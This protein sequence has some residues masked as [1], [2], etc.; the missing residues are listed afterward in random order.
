MSRDLLLVSIALFTWGVGESAYFFF[1]PLY[2][3]ALGASPLSIGTIMG[4]VGIA[5]II[6]HIPAGYLADR[7]GRR[8]MMWI[9]W[10][11]GVLSGVIMASARSLPIFTVGAVL[12]GVTAFV[13]TPLNSYVTAARGKWSV[14]RALTLTSAAYSSGAIVGPIVGGYI[15]ERYDFSNL[16]LFATCMF[17]LS[18]IV[19]FFLKPQPTEKKEANDPQNKIFKRAYL[20]FL[21]VLFTATL[22]MYLSQ[23]LAPNFL[24]NV[25]HLSISQIGLLGSVSSTGTVILN[26]VIGTLNART[27]LILSQVAAGF[28]PL[29]LWKG[30]GLPWFAVAYFML[31]GYRAARS[32]SIAHIRSLI[33]TANM[34][35]AYG[36]A[37]TV[38]GAA[39]ILAPP[40]A[41]FLYENNPVWI[42][43][44]GLG[45]SFIAF[46]L[47]IATIKK[48]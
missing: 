26:L 38:S 2:L 23:P 20:V 33:S 12:Y 28:F 31:G 40:L 36:I 43:Q 44:A 24:Q 21:P 35:L 27:G 29:L 45:L 22:G 1:Q 39:I 19:I 3:E 11:V 5:M 4:A 10:M 34:G 14:A 42:F 13:I 9:S 7:F 30:L 6:T 32:V 17:L 18:T 16:Y 47:T 37:E 41:G 48:T 8:I 15:G 46:M 25:H